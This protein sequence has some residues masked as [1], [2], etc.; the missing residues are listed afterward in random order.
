MSQ[1]FCKEFQC[2]EI[3]DANERNTGAI[4]FVEV[5]EAKQRLVCVMF[6]KSESVCQERKTNG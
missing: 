1:S 5:G 6:T 3:E 4:V 2:Q